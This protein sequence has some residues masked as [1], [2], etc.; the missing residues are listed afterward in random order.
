MA[1][2]GLRKSCYYCSER[3]LGQ[4]LAS[5]PILKLK[6]RV[7]FQ[8]LSVILSGRN[9]IAFGVLGLQVHAETLP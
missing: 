5:V 9:V 3:V 2:L 8:G 4:I 7:R 6:F 1:H